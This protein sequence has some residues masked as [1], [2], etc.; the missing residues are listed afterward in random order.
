[1]PNISVIY[2]NVCI[3]LW[4]L[5]MEKVERKMCSACVEDAQCGRWKGRFN[6]SGSFSFHLWWLSIGVW[7]FPLTK[8]LLCLL[9]S[10]TESMFLTINF[11]DSWLERSMCFSVPTTSPPLWLFVIALLHAWNH[12]VNPTSP[13]KQTDTANPSPQPFDTS[14]PCLLPIL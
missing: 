8:T 5:E 13:E 10:E 7:L 4:T 6:E 3:I 11:Q 1:M 2:S 12:R 9:R 14:L